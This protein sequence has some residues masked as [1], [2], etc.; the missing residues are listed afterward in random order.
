MTSSKSY[1]LILLQEEAS[2]QLEF[3]IQD[4]GQKRTT[5]SAFRTDRALFLRIIGPEDAVEVRVRVGTDVV[6]FLSAQLTFAERNIQPWL[7]DLYGEAELVVECRSAFEFDAQWRVLFVAMLPLV[8]P[9]ETAVLYETLLIELEQA[10]R[11]LTRDFI[12]GAV[13]MRHDP[14]RAVFDPSTETER[15]NRHFRA[16]KSALAKIAKRPA[17]NFALTR[18]T[19]RYRPG[20]RLDPAAMLSLPRD[21]DTV[22]VGKMPQSIGKITTKR[23]VASED[24]AEHRHLRTA[25]IHLARRAEALHSGCIKAADLLAREEETWGLKRQGSTASVYDERFAP[26]VEKLRELA[27]EAQALEKSLRKMVRD[28]AFLAT[29][30]APH[31]RLESTPRFLSAKGYS[32]A[33]RTLRE[34]TAERE[35][36]PDDLT[37]IRLRR[38]DLLYEYWTYVCTI[39]ILQELLGEPEEGGEFQVVDETYRPELSPGQRVVWRR[40][41]E[42]RIYAYYEPAIPPFDAPAPGP[43]G[44]RA[45]IV[46][47]PV[48]PDVL[49]VLDQPGRQPRALALDAKSTPRFDRRN[50]TQ[51]TDYRTYVHDPKTNLQPIRQMFFVHRDPRGSF[52]SFPGHFDGFLPLWENSVVGAVPLLPGARD[53][54]TY[55]IET[56]LL[57]PNTRGPLAE[58]QP[59]SAESPAGSDALGTNDREDPPVR[60]RDWSP[61]RSAWANAS[62]S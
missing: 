50:L 13:L 18:T 44:W 59:A 41:D 15:L 12:G 56:F 37:N 23:L 51:Y 45:S 29:A 60:T 11:S 53:Q 20:D 33:F 26:R 17:T 55:V 14:T 62:D 9:R 7:N 40:D 3:E 2:A 16:L 31:T 36:G 24:I 61:W 28:H 47:A 35:H 32:D 49:I 57:T 46:G 52:S 19:Q 8:V 1:E 4:S 10:H 54:L 5:R 25:I 30:S 39:S 34:L 6:G 21:K 58:V 42:S 27:G 22:F 38:L 43:H 48:R